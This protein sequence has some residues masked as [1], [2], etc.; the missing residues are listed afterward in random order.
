MYGLS[1]TSSVIDTTD[2]DLDNG[3]LQVFTL[4]GDTTFTFTSW[5]EDSIYAKVRVHIKSDGLD[6]WTATFDSENGGDIVASTTFP[7]PLT[8][9]VNGKHKVVEAW[10]YDN[11]LKVYLN[12]IGEF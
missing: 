9:S 10:S 8:V 4:T 12:Y 1:L 6:E 3:S 2:I 7:S 11:G 5:P